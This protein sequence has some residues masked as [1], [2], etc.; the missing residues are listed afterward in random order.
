MRERKR[1]WLIVAGLTLMLVAPPVQLVSKAAF[2][3][4]W[5][6]GVA[7]AGVWLVLDSRAGQ[8]G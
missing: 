7:L 1:Y 6:A 4:L 5:Y 8:R 3:A 2:L